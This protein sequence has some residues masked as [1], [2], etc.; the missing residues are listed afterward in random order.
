MAWLFFIG[1]ICRKLKFYADKGVF[2]DITEVYTRKL[3]GSSKIGEELGKSMRRTCKSGHGQVIR[4]YIQGIYV[5][6]GRQESLKEQKF[7]QWN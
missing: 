6:I 1:Q 3:F 5:D 4:C 7:V 2:S